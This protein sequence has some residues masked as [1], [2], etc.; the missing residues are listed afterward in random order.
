MTGIFI[1]PI[2]VKGKHKFDEVEA[3]FR[4]IG[5]DADLNYEA[6]FKIRSNGLWESIRGRPVTVAT[7]RVRTSKGKSW[8]S[9]LNTPASVVPGDSLTV[10]YHVMFGDVQR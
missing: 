10:F 5:N 9:T 8:Y 2:D 1:T 7:I 6:S 3:C 4:S